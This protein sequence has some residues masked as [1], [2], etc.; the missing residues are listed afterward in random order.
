MT[1]SKCRPL[2]SSWRSVCP[3]LLFILKVQLLAFILSCVNSAPALEIYPFL[4]CCLADKTSGLWVIS[5]SCM[6]ETGIFLVIL[7]TSRCWRL[8]LQ[9]LPMVVAYCHR[10]TLPVKSIGEER[11]ALACGPYVSG[12]ITMVCGEAQSR[13]WQNKTAHSI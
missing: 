1:W 12:C 6:K 7:S 2:G 3:G 5:F 11:V 4:P 10:G 9:G 13:A 8:C